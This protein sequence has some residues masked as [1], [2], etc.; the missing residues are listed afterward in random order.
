LV[1]SWEEIGSH[2]PEVRSRNWFTKSFVE[3]F[4]VGSFRGFKPV[5]GNREM[6]FDPVNDAEGANMFRFLSLLTGVGVTVGSVLGECWEKSFSGKNDG[7]VL[8][9]E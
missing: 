3:G 9:S 1:G 6:L 2:E 4:L 7:F 8:R 5:V